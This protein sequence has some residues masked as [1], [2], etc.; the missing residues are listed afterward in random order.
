MPWAAMLYAHVGLADSAS[1]TL[2]IWKEMFT[3]PG[4]GSRHNPYFPG[5]SLMKQPFGS[6]GEG[7]G[8]VMQMDGAMASVAAVHYMLCHERQGAIR[9]FAGA[10]VT[11]KKVSFDGILTDGG[12]L[13]S[14]E[15]IDGKVTSVTLKATRAATVR[16]ASPWKKGE[17]IDVNLKSGEVRVLINK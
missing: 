4:H 16:I 1:L 8:E 17:F 13:V 15:R 2:R 12:V 5:Y 3:N 11:W 10:P 14:A 9:L 6:R 7:G